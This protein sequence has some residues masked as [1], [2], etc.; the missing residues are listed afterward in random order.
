MAAAETV[1]LPDYIVCLKKE[2]SFVHFD[3]LLGNMM[4]NE[5]LSSLL[6]LQSEFCLHCYCTML[7][8]RQ[9]NEGI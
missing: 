9:V 6:V 3:V 7:I 5:A 1:L 4:H 8:E 2:T